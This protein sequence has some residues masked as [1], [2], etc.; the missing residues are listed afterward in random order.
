MK[1]LLFLIFL[2][3]HFFY[4]FSQPTLHFDDK[5]YYLDS[6]VTYQEK[7]NGLMFRESLPDNEGM[8]FIYDK[9]KII[10]MWMDNTFLPL[11]IIWLDE[12]FKIT[13]LIS[14]PP[15]NSHKIYSSS[16]LSQYV[17]ELPYGVIS[18]RQL[19]INQT[20]KVKL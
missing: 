15:L 10:S 18:Q 19:M 6:A 14:N 8:I 9:P 2:L 3:S 7:K 12:F 4:L 20:L 13:Y 5:I 1:G 17:L 16:L 11:D